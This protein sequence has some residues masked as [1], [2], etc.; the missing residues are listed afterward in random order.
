MLNIRHVAMRAKPPLR[1]ALLVV[2]TKMQGILGLWSV[3]RNEL[4]L[5]NTR[6]R[7]PWEVDKGAEYWKGVFDINIGA[8]VADVTRS[9]GMVDKDRGMPDI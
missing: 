3:C 6:R 9:K 5:L 4:R 8:S 7:Q 1:R 2:S